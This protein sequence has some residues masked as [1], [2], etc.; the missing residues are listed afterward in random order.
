MG[1][2]ADAII[3]FSLCFWFL[4]LEPVISQKYLCDFWRKRKVEDDS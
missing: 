1:S 2:I 3:F 4:F